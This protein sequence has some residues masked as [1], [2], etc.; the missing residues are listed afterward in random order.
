MR[1]IPS[2]L[3]LA[4]WDFCVDTMEEAREENAGKYRLWS[5]EDANLLVE[6]HEAGVDINEI[7]ARFSR[8]KESCRKYYRL[9]KA[10]KVQ[11]MQ[12]PRA[13]AWTDAQVEAL[14]SMKENSVSYPEIA[15]ALNRS[16]DACRNKMSLLKKKDAC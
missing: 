13:N 11:Q 9:I 7:A 6:M 15:K 2:H 3:R 4:F 10:G 8:T 12:K 5:K 1:K 14:V 16:I